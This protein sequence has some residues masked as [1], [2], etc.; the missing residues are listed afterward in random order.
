M[1][2]HRFAILALAASLAACVSP[3]QREAQYE[4]KCAALG[5]PRGSEHYYDCRLR[6]EQIDAINNAAILD[7]PIYQPA[8][9]PAP[10]AIVPFTPAPY[11][12]FN[13]PSGPNFQYGR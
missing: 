6:L 2:T 1:R 8:A 11:G 13:A 9:P 5:V 3:Q 4:A 7:A 10:P 12:G